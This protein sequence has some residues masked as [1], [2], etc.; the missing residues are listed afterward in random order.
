M[1]GNK[2]SKKRGLWIAIIGL[3][4][5]LVGFGEAYI[6][7]KGKVLES[8]KKVAAE[9]AARSAEEYSKSV[10]AENKKLRERIERQQDSVR[11]FMVVYREYLVGIRNASSRLREVRTSE[12]QKDLEVRILAFVKFM[13]EWRTVQSE[14]RTLLDGDVDALEAAAKAGTW[15][16]VEKRSRVLERNLDSKQPILE[17]QIERL[18]AKYGGQVSTLNKK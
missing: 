9:S 8:T 10:E 15:G 11:R 5:T 14:L 18:E 3:L 1:V 2:S 16:E 13:N 6:Q 17:Q 7:Y 12:A 4:T